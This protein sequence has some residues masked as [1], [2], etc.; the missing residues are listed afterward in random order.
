MSHK[1]EMKLSLNNKE[2]ILKA[3]DALNIKYQVATET[4]GLTTKG[5]YGVHE[6]VDI[7]ITEVNG[8]NVTECIGLQYQTDGTYAATGDFHGTGYNSSGFGEKLT[9]EAKKIESI[10][11]L[12]GMNF[13]LA[14]TQETTQEVRMVFQRWM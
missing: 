3:L 8:R 1:T 7:L 4:N 10:D 13:N 9:T 6:K 14:D 2:C 12:T 5:H 11:M